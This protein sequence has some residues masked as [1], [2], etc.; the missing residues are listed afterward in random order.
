MKQLSAFL[1]AAF[2]PLAQA[3]TLKAVAPLG[4][5]SYN[6]ASVSITGG[7]INGTSIGQTTPAAG[8]F[9]SVNGAPFV[10]SPCN[11]ASLVAALTTAGANAAATV[12]GG[13]ACTLTSNVTLTDGQMMIFG[14]G[15]TVS[16]GFSI[17]GIPD[18]T[19]L[20][21]SGVVEGRYLGSVGNEWTHSI[22]AEVPVTSGTQNYE[23]APL[24]IRV[25]CLDPSDYASNY[26]RDCVGLESQAEIIT[27]N[28][29]GRAWSYDSVTTVD[30]GADGY[31]IGAEHSINNNGTA[32]TSTDQTNS[33]VA[34]HLVTQG[35]S[36]AT[37]ASFTSKVSGAGTFQ[38]GYIVG[39]GSVAGHAFGV[40][41]G[42]T[43]AS[44]VYY[45]DASGNVGAVSY[46]IAGVVQ[47]A[48]GAYFEASVP[49]I[50]PSSGS[51]GNNGALTVTTALDTT[52]SAGA[53]FF[54]PA[55]AISSGSAAGWYWGIGSS[56]SA[57]TLFNN[58]YSS[59]VPIAPGS[60]TPF[61][62]TG[63]GAYV[64]SGGAQ[65]AISLTIPGGSMGASGRIISDFLI[66]T[67]NS[68]GTK[69]FTTSYG[70]TQF[71][72]DFP[73][74]STYLSARTVIRNAGVSAQIGSTGIEGQTLSGSLVRGTVNSASNQTYTF[75]ITLGTPATD[76][77]I[78]QALTLTVQ[79]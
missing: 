15:S 40:R 50:L 18:G 39:P 3:G 63:P 32:Q 13:V 5:S 34:E 41:T 24:Y 20:G 62:T 38:D 11:N 45:V 57:I 7:T 76:Y 31:A 28:T 49:M 65:S 26:S 59:G 56:A 72:G 69:A 67:D 46:A 51:M 74:A 23:K 78:L 35:T 79:Q 73:T 29:T 54:M 70:G 2:I 1:I 8:S 37:A 6:P 61:V 75:K 36:Q 12:N 64:Q 22:Q 30:S 21:I 52:Y 19:A 10:A 47:P 77:A 27:G 55:G 17:G 66:S 42:T 68:A 60:T 48:T 25:S 44:D 16:G 58:T 4:G 53:Y 43:D 33:K 14:N 71:F 9:T